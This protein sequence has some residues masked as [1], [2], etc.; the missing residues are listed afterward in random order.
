MIIHS[1]R[2]NKVCAD[3]RKDFNLCR[4]SILGKMIEPGYCEEKAAKVIDC[5]QSV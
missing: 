3:A 2:A 1:A 4:A 5:F